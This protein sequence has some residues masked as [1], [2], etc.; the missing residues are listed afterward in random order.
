VPL[1][2]QQAVKLKE[3][4]SATVTFRKGMAGYEANLEGHV[5][6][7]PPVGD[8]S[9]GTITIKLEVPNPEKK[10]T[11]GEIVDVHF[12]APKVAMKP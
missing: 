7:I 12:T 9:S 3:G 4:D 11:P 6:K 10:I 1:P 2:I 5:K 8:A